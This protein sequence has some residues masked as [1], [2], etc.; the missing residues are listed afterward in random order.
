MLARAL[1]F[2]LGAWCRLCPAVEHRV[3]WARDDEDAVRTAVLEVVRHRRRRAGRRLAER[4]G[5]D[6]AEVALKYPRGHVA[7]PG[8]WLADEV[9]TMAGR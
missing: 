8:E 2:R 9:L 7:G 1:G 5:L 6:P 4:A 3:R